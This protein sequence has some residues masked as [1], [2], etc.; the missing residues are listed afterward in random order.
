MAAIDPLSAVRGYVEA[1][2]AQDED[3]MA[4][5][6]APSGAILDGMAPH[7]W[8]GSTAARDWWRDVLKEGERHGASDYRVTL[9]EPLHHDVTGDAAYVVVPA[10]MTFSLQGRQVTQSGAL[11]TAALR[12]LPDGWRV[13]A[14]AW[15]KGPRPA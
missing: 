2:N 10:T 1:F 15:S 12:R 13:V 6:F 8:Q 14:W 9:G 11:F 7:L 5:A 3:A 4:A